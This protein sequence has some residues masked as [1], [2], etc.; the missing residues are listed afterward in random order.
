MKS[1]TK[2]RLVRLILVGCIVAIVIIKLSGGFGGKK[3]LRYVKQVKYWKDFKDIRDQKWTIQPSSSSQRL[4][5]TQERIERANRAGLIR[6]RRLI[7]GM[8]A[9]NS[10]LLVIL[11]QVHSRVN[12]LQALIDSLRDT[13]GIQQTLVV[14]S[15]DV[16]D[17]TMNKLV[18]SIRFCA[19]LQIFYPHAMQV[20]PN[21]FPGRSAC[22]CPKNLKKSE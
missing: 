11:V 17:E 3:K 5:E 1:F 13:K 18:E 2:N 8:L 19:T 6:N 4:D 14:F 20:Y 22:D 7:E 10:S 16:Y 9:K 12:Y 15:H 21:R